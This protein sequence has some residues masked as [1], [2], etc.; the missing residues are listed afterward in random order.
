[1][2]IGLCERSWVDVKNIKIGKRSHL[3][4]ESTDKISVLYN[5][6]N[7]HDARINRNIMEHIDDESPNEMFDDD[8]IK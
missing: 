7:I 5:T 1:M 8:D 2:E 3:G 4:G 6:A